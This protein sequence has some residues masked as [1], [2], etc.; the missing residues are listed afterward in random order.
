[1]GKDAKLRKKKIGT[2]VGEERCR[3]CGKHT[4]CF[5]QGRSFFVFAVIT[6]NHWRNSEILVVCFRV[7]WRRVGR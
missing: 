2:E 4:E 5:T 7:E 6:G 3:W 1:M